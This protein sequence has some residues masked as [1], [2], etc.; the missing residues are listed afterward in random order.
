MYHELVDK[1]KEYGKKL[2][3]AK[4]LEIVETLE[5][6][7]NAGSANIMEAMQ[8]VL[9]YEDNA[10]IRFCLTQLKNA[11]QEVVHPE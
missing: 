11:A 10:Q 3:N 4:M 8:E 5:G 1:I 2:S 7:H 6:Y 9:K